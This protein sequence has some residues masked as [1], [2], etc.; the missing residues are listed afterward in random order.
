MENDKKGKEP[1]KLSQRVLHPVAECARRV[2]DV[3]NSTATLG[4]Q[5]VAQWPLPLQVAAGSLETSPVLATMVS[6]A[7]IIPCALIQRSHGDF[8]RDLAYPKPFD[9]DRAEACEER[10][11]LRVKSGTRK[12][13]LPAFCFE[14]HIGKTACG[15]SGTLAERKLSIWKPTKLR[16]K[17]GYWRDILK[18]R[19]STAMYE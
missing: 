16:S 6:I 17:D 13:R 7:R 10:P 18:H 9:A 3:F 15:G 8:A 19:T 12:A 1:A 11:H 4:H 14:G 2:A 5:V